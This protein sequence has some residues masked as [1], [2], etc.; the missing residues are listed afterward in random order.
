[1]DGFDVS[2]EAVAHARATYGPIRG[3]G[4]TRATSKTFVREAQPESYDL[5]TA[6]EVIEHVDENAAGAAGRHRARAGSR[7]CGADLPQPDKQLYWR[8]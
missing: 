7:R 2:A 3:L 1:V 8:T 4:F 6:F 5:V